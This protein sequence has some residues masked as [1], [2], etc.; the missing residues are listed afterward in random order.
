MSN[1]EEAVK[2][3]HLEKN[4]EEVVDETVEEEVE[5]TEED[6]Q[7]P[8]YKAKLN[9]QNRLLKKEG[10]EFKEGKWVKPE[11]PTAK[12]AAPKK[13]GDISNRDMYDLIEAKVPKQD[14]DEVVS[15]AK[16][17]GISI[18][19]ALE[20]DVV[21]TIL[22][23]NGEMRTTASAAHTGTAK[24]GSGKLSDDV[25]L[26]KASKGEDIDDVDALVAAR[27]NNMKQK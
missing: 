4:D 13:N 7:E 2:D 22:S 3:E 15:Y 24:R 20:D 11:K 9:I 21:K 5:E 23:N 26:A 1:N 6:N 18:A 10:Y 12:K 14:I 19:D 27:M 25:I 16:F 17:K 8:D